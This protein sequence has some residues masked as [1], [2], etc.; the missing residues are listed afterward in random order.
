MS[1]RYPDGCTRQIRCLSEKV[2]THM[3]LHFLM[4]L[5]FLFKL[6][7]YFILL[8]LK[9]WGD[10]DTDQVSHEGSCQSPWRCWPPHHGGCLQICSAVNIYSSPS[11]FLPFLFWVPK[12]PCYQVCC[13]RGND[14]LFGW[15]RQRPRTKQRLEPSSLKGLPMPSCALGPSMSVSPTVQSF[16]PG[17]ADMH[18]G[19]TECRRRMCQ[20][21]RR[22]G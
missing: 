22:E 19:P 11:W 15:L 16:T 7:F 4:C 6:G 8:P 14:Q 18:Q 5:K 9:F 13:V 21:M 2:L 1:L 10:T 3:V 17:S 20:F 12:I